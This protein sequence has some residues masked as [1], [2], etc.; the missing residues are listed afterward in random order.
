MPFPSL[1][2]KVIAQNDYLINIL[3]ICDMLE[4]RINNISEMP[5]VL[6]PGL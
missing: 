5:W 1:T 4:K 2:Q 3:Y 6:I